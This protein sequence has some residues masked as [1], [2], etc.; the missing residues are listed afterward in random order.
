MSEWTE[1]HPGL[2][3]PEGDNVEWQFKN[4]SEW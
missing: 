2:E 3:W 1:Y 4:T